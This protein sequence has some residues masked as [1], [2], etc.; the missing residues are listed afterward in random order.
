MIKVIFLDN[1]AAHIERYE[2]GQLKSRKTVK[3]L[4]ALIWMNKQGRKWAW[5]HDEEGHEMATT[6]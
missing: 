1:V 6:E 4:S 2:D 5:G 3:S